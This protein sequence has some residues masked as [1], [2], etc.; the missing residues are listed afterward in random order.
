MKRIPYNGG[1][2]YLKSRQD[3]KNEVDLCLEFKGG[4]NFYLMTFWADGIFNRWPCIRIPELQ[5]DDRGR[6]IEKGV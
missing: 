1:H 3:R 5:T 2:L 4:V 6:I